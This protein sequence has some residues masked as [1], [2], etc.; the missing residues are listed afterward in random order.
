MIN[1]LSRI[2]APIKRQIYML[3]GRAIVTYIDNSKS[4]QLLQ[5]SLLADEVSSNVERFEEYGFST[6]PLTGAEAIAGFINGNRSHG[7][8]LCVHDRRYRPTDLAE[9]EVAIY[10]DEDQSSPNH[11]IHLKNGNEI[12]IKCQDKV[13]ILG[14]DKTETISGSKQITITGDQTKNAANDTETI[15]TNKQ[16]VAAVIVL[17]APS[18]TLGGIAGAG[19]TLATSDIVTV[20]NNHTHNE[21]GSVTAVPNTLLNSGNMTANVRGV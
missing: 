16:I 2:L 7:I 20:F 8:V 1:S 6:Y 21:T 15:T 13:E 4:T 19:K 12:E 5:L 18:V 14:G 11:R 9:G 17:N 10:T 3:I